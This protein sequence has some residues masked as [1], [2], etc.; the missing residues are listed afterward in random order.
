MIQ[1][2]K[3]EMLSDDVAVIATGGFAPKLNAYTNM[4]DEV[5]VNLTLKG[6][7]I[8]YSKISSKA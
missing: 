1:R 8:I 7:E 3:K 2:I 6:L 4:I 5:D